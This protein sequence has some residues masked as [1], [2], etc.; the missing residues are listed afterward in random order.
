MP[1]SWWSRTHL[2][3]S[4]KRPGALWTGQVGGTVSQGLKKKFLSLENASVGRVT[5]VEGDTIHGSTK[6]EHCKL[7]GLYGIERFLTLD[8]D[9]M[10][11]RPNEVQP[12]SFGVAESLATCQTEIITRWFSSPDII[13]LVGW[14]A[15]WFNY[16]RIILFTYNDIFSSNTGRRALK[17]VS[18]RP[19]GEVESSGFKGFRLT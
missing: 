1:P 6:N 2:C 15:L 10:V 19:L 5:R 3:L 17:T 7:E 8:L 14:I 18:V 13:S 16:T 11:L 4:S 12:R 9:V